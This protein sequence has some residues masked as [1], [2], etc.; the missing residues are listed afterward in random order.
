MTFPKLVK[1]AAIV[2]ACLGFFGAWYFAFSSD[3]AKLAKAYL[4]E[5]PEV[6]TKY[7]KT[8]NPLLSGFRMTSSK[9]LMTFWT[10]TPSGRKFITVTID[11]TNTPW[12]VKLQE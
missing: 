8:V 12:A 3:E 9:S 5:S 1:R 10:Q 4:L 11:K 6:V 7:G 2:L